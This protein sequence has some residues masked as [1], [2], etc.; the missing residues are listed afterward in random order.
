LLIREGREV[1]GH[2]PSTTVQRVQF[3]LFVSTREGD[4][5]IDQEG[6]IPKAVKLQIHVLG[7]SNLSSTIV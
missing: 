4:L 2:H 5:A 7:A 3:S 1:S 6:F